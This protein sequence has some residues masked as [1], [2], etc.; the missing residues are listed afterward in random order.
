MGINEGTNAHKSSPVQV[1]GTTWKSV[2][3]SPFIGNATKTDGTLWSW[4]YNGPGAL[5]HNNRTAYSS[6][7]Q[8]PG[9]WNRVGTVTGGYV[10]MAHKE[11]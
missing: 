1:P 4:G 10:V 9:T 8:I 2:T 6:P 5:G 11:V 3:I 7:T